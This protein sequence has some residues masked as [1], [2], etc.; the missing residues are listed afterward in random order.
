MSKNFILKF[1]M[2]AIV[3]SVLAALSTSV[4][5]WRAT[6]K[7]NLEFRI[8]GQDFARVLYELYAWHR[9]QLADY[10]EH[11]KEEVVRQALGKYDSVAEIARLNALASKLR[12]REYPQERPPRIGMELKEGS[13]I[14]LE[15]WKG[16]KL[17][18][19]EREYYDGVD[20]FYTIVWEYQRNP[21]SE[22][23][24]WA[25]LAFA[26]VLTGLAATVAIWRLIFLPIIETMWVITLRAISDISNAIRGNTK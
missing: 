23:T 26:S 6:K 22:A 3:V 21:L 12:K 11:S 17:S 8:N 1:I 7:V 18:D 4:Y 13:F 15:R 19:A 14:R 24:W 10:K 16:D 20:E 25:F 2:V 9:N 5:V